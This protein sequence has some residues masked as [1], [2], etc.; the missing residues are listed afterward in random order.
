MSTR[1]KEKW[2]Y[3]AEYNGKEEGC[4]EL[5]LNLFVFFKTIKRGMRVC[6]TAYDMGAPYEI[7]AW[8]QSTNKSLL[9]SEPPYYLIEKK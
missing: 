4:G 5:I 8:C 2:E 6:V 1:N 7:K 9:E 3:D